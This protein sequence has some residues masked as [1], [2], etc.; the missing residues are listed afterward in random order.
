MG[1]LK[2]SI[3]QKH[4]F[5]YQIG[6][7][8]YAIGANIFAQITDSDEIDNMELLSN[9]LNKNTERQIEALLEQDDIYDLF[10]FLEKL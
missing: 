7:A 9:A 4:G 3:Y 6:E 10:E 2:E 5:I 8:Y 1:S